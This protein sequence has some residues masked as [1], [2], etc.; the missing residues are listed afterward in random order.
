MTSA[1]FWPA[2]VR[3]WRWDCWSASHNKR[4]RQTE[5]EK[6]E[7]REEVVEADDVLENLS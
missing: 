1:V 5:E 4:G 3:F 7:K 6:E 2:G